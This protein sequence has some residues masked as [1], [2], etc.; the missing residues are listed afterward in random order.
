M[1]SWFAMMLGWLGIGAWGMTG[2]GPVELTPEVA[3]ARYA[4]AAAFVQPGGEFY[5]VRNVEGELESRLRAVFHLS[6]AFD[7]RAEG[8]YA[9]H[10]TFGLLL[11]Y[12]REQG[13]FSTWTIAGSL[14][15]EGAGVYSTRLF[16]AH[17]PAARETTFWR[18][19]TGDEPSAPTLLDRL[20]ADTVWFLH[21]RC[22]PDTVWIAVREGLLKF[23][24]G[25]DAPTL[26]RML[27]DAERNLGVKLDDFFGAFA[28][29]TIVSLQMDETRRIPIPLPGGVMQLPAPRLLIMA[30][31]R[32][33]ALFRRAAAGIEKTGLPRQEIAEGAG[34]RAGIAAPVPPFDFRMTACQQGD[35]FVLAS[36]P[37]AV[38]AALQAT[39]GE[40]TQTAAFQAA[41][42][43]LP[44][45]HSALVFSDARLAKAVN[46]VI[47][48]LKQGGPAGALGM[49]VMLMG[50]MS[51]W[52]E[53]TSATAGI[54]L[55]EGM[56]WTGT[57]DGQFVRQAAGG[58]GMNPMLMAA[59]AVPSF[60]KARTTA[61]VN[62]CI[63]NLR[64]LDAAKEQ[65]ALANGK[66]EGDMP[67]TQGVGEYIRGGFER[68]RCPQGGTYTL[69]P[70][71]ENPT[72]SH[73]GH[74]LR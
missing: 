47:E 41:V 5:L 55:P 27:S 13:V 33:D 37:E 25:G 39:G 71:G 7:I 63:N 36:S 29:E 12:L 74:A 38:D 59:I 51:D 3:A 20:P 62:S 50:M 6:G 15:P 64:Q 48:Q 53:T 65:W 30:K 66:R 49:N 70:I 34:M 42:A 40:L 43:G 57:G 44:T 16:V 45:R 19:L 54:H 58:G 60:M 68:L 72:C 23:M 31:T 52:P 61:S 8:A 22:R 14:Q 1:N 18:G 9:A 21:T 4:T 69:G 35:L 10:Q 24:C 32:N 26:A 67:D 17:D 56:L 46:G 73:L 11:E 2:G 28:G